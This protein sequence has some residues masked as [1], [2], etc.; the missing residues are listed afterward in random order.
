LKKFLPAPINRAYLTFYYHDIRCHRNE[1]LACFILR[2]CLTAD[3]TPF[4]ESG[5]K[6]FSGQTNISEIHA[7]NIFRGVSRR[8]MAF[9]VAIAT[10]A[11]EW[12]Q[13]PI[14]QTV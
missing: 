4:Y 3:P 6:I 12:R 14:R 13:A 10:T 9:L 5:L 1:V 11:I 2:T 8:C 7:G